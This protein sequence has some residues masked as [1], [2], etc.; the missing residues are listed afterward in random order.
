MAD[1]QFEDE[2]LAALYDLFCPWDPRGDFSYYFPLV[3]AARSVLDVGC[4]TGMLLHRAREA[5]HTGRLTGIDPAH[6]MLEVARARTDIEW[7]HGDLST[8]AP[9][10]AFDLVV[11]SGHAFQVFVTDDELRA[12]L[13]AIRSLLSED[14][15]FAFDTR[16]PADRAWER[17]TPEHGREVTGPGGE[18]IRSEH[19]VTAAGGGTVSFTT[20]YTT[21]GGPPELSHSTLRFLDRPELAAFL[22]EAGLETVVQHGDWDGSPVTDGSIE[23]ITVARRA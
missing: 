21:D 22:A 7:I 8:A 1:R 17:W 11:M 15:R 2:S 3:M 14:G 23:I 13:A 9:E 4:G 19:R 20:S 16:N 18:L 5:G 6:G 10:G 12:N